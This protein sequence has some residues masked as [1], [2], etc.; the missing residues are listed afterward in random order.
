[1]EIKKWSLKVVVLIKKL[2]LKI[3]IL[4]LK[5]NYFA[6][7][8]FSLFSKSPIKL[9]LMKNTLKKRKTGKKEN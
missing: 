7:F 6:I 5:N 1:M 2:I 9:P 4:I 3:V 8:P